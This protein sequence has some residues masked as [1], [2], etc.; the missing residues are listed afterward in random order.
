LPSKTE[1]FTERTR[2]AIPPRELAPLVLAFHVYNRAHLKPTFP[3]IPENFHTLEH[4]EKTLETAQALADKLTDFNFF[5]FDRNDSQSI[6]GTVQL[7]QIMRG[8]FQAAYLGFSAAKAAEGK[9]LIFEAVQRVIRFAFEDL[10]LHRLMANHLPENARS[11]ALI[12]RLGFQ[13]EG[14]GKDY[15]FINGRWRDHV[16]NI[17]TN[18]EWQPRAQDESYFAPR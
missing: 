9:G 18:P 7:S 10:H 11:A 4:F 14:V 16:L 8:P 5:I 6:L 17:L 12:K 13:Y 1:L 2:L 3:P 15:L